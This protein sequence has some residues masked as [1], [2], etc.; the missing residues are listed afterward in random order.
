MMK[1]GTV[2]T[3]NTSLGHLPCSQLVCKLP[4][5]WGSSVLSLRSLVS[6]SVK[7]DNSVYLK[8]PLGGLKEMMHKI[9]SQSSPSSDTPSLFLSVLICEMGIMTEPVSKRL[10]QFL[11]SF[12]LLHC[13]DVSWSTIPYPGPLGTCVLGLGVFIFYF[14]FS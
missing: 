12:L 10:L 3:L 8:G 9:C 14:W 7:W 6:L 11:L 2:P 5:C 4:G 1:V 13:S